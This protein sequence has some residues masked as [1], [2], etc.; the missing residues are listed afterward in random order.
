MAEYS[1]NLPILN[2]DINQFWQGCKREVLL[3]QKCRDCGKYR[4]EPRAVCPY[5]LSLNVRWVKVSGR[6]EVYSFVIYRQAPIPA[7]SD[8]VPYVVAIIELEDCG[9][10]MVSNIV[11]CEPEDVKIGM[12]VEV[13][14]E[15][16]TEEITLPK[17]KPAT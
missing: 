9:V 4:H 10:R 13:T 5:C 8:A 3:I 16:V 12:K 15:K 1:R 7:W 6:G 2:P 11:G 14:F 17:F